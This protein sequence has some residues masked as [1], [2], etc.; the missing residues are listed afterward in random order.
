MT[1][2]YL[3]EK[4]DD[5][6]SG[7][8]EDLAKQ[9]FSK[10]PESPCSK[11][12]LTY[13][14]KSDPDATSFVF[15]ILLTIYL[16]GFMNILDVIK[17]NS[18]GEDNDI[19]MNQQ[20]YKNMDI[21]DLQFPEPWFKSFGFSINIKEYTRENTKEIDKLKSLSYCRILLSFDSKDIFYFLTRKIDKKYTFIL[22]GSYRPTN[23][24][25]KIYAL[26]S[27]D[28]KLYQISFNHLQN[29]LQ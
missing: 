10:E 6:V 26:L 29:H 9:L 28:D 11:Q 16:E 5:A 25:E 27:K 19:S 8:P 4:I 22:S 17:Q 2:K 15:E 18:A 1:E 21:N 24:L 3:Q 23:K 7:S 20:A 13:S 14:A 12:I